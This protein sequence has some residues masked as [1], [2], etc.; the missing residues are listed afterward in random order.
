MGSIIVNKRRKRERPIETYEEMKTV[1]RKRFVSSHYYRRLYHKLQSLTQYNRSV[2]DN[3]KEMEILMVRANVE[4]D[5]E[6]TMAKF[7]VCLN[8]EIDNIMELQHYVELE[9]MAHMAI[10][11]E[12][13][14]KRRGS[15]TRQTPYMGSTW[16]PIVMKKEKL[17]STKLKTENMQE[18]TIHGS[19]GKGTLPLL[20]IVILNALNAKAGIT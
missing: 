8:R 10:K 3:H 6:A 11:V 17:V 4:E 15:N 12:N 1:M 13:Q 16:R 5:K 7:V 9:D 14:L 20:E 19:Q 18:T 2:E